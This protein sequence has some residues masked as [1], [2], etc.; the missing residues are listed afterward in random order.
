TCHST[1]CHSTT[2]HSTTCHS[3]MCHS[4]MCHSTMCH[5]TT[6]HSTMCHS[7]MCHSITCH[8]TIPNQIPLKMSSILHLNI[9]V[10]QG[11]NM[12]PSQ[13]WEMY[14]PVRLLS[15]CL[16]I[17]KAWLVPLKCRKSEVPLQNDSF[18]I[19]QACTFF[20]VF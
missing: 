8:S 18:H 9:C 11:N 13:P 20:P 12:A 7:T 3:T 19:T 15:L 16:C 2:C 14:C 4:T 1:T 17:G 6:C 10:L 5:S